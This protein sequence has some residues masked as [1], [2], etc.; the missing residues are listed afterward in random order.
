MVVSMKPWCRGC[1]RRTCTAEVVGCEIVG[2]LVG[3]VVD[4]PAVAERAVGYVGDVELADGVDK[5]VGLVQG[6]E[7]GVFGLDSVDPGD[8]DCVRNGCGTS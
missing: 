2:S 6:L 4:E 7:G 1:P 5:A 8:W 3:E